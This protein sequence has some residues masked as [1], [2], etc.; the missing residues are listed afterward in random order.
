MK[1]FYSFLIAAVALVGFAACESN[2]EQAPV[3]DGVMSFVASFDYTRTE[4]ADESGV[5]AWC[6][7]DTI[8]VS[9]G[10]ETK[11][12]SISEI[13]E[14]G[15]AVFTGERMDGEVFTAIYPYTEE[16]EWTVATEQ[17]AVAGSFAHGAAVSTAV[18]E[19]GKTLSFKNECAILKFQV[20]ADATSVAFYNG[21]E[22]VVEVVGEMTV[23]N[24]YYAVVMPG[25]YTFTVKIN[26]EVSKES[27]KALELEANKIYNLKALPVVLGEAH[28]MFGFV[29]A[30]QGWNTETPDALYQISGS[31]TYVARNVTL[32]DGGFKFYGSSSKTVIVEHPA[33][34]TGE[35]GDLYLVPNNN[36]KEANARFAAYFFGGASGT[37]WVDMK[38][39]NGDGIY[40]VNKP[41]TGT[42][43][44]VI[45]CRMN[46]A[47]SDNNWNE[48]TKWNQTGDLTIPTDGKNC[49]TVP[50]GYWDGAT[51]TWSVHTP[52]IK[53]A[54]T[55]E[56]EEITSYWFGM[57]ESDNISNWVTGY[58]NN[59]GGNNITVADYS[60]K[61]DIY[62]CKEADQ[63]WG[64]V[65]HFAVRE[66]GSAMPELK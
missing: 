56:V 38:D 11:E 46:P 6:E 41:E 66:S 17:E 8:A 5:V 10:V 65:F 55:E 61:Y 2:V 3:Q 40:V 62:F 4:L 37:T 23:G 22:L 54:W 25:T 58:S 44:K 64:F 51:T 32:A 45:F 14:D 48:G 60:K 39:S 18:S 12:F 15:S 16:A 53:D 27:T 9:N 21:E 29:G 13:L 49:F 59:Y 28:E 20:P 50:S 35:E 47:T 34:T 7:E 19:D 33:V 24:N 42:Y 43:P 30:H 1:K 26:G 31:N 36:W 57:K 63:D 52:E